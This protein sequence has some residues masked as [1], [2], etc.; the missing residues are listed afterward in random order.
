MWMVID[1]QVE[2][3]F[4]ITLNA[5]VLGKIKRNSRESKQ[6]KTGTVGKY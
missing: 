5:A 4:L 2:Q 3:S 6:N 1:Q